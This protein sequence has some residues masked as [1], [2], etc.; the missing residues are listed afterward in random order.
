MYAFKFCINRDKGLKVDPQCNITHTCYGD[1]QVPTFFFFFGNMRFHWESKYKEASNRKIGPQTCE[2]IILSNSILQHLKTIISY[3]ILPNDCQH[4][5]LFTMLNRTPVSNRHSRYHL[6]L[7]VSSVLLV[8][9]NFTSIKT[10]KKVKLEAKRK[11]EEK[12]PL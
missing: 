9:N 3:F 7:K 11:G 12:L 5:S 2:R 10:S 6:H 8:D 1:F 4:Q